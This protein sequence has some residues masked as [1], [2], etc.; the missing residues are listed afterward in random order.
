MDRF[1][2]SESTQFSQEWVV[3]VQKGGR[4][5]FNTSKSLG[6]KDPS[7]IE[8][9]LASKPHCWFRLYSC[10]HTTCT[11]HTNTWTQVFFFLFTW[12]IV[13]DITI[14]LATESESR[15]MVWKVKCKMFL[16]A[17]W[18]SQK[19][20]EFCLPITCHLGKCQ[21]I[22]ELYVYH[23]LSILFCRV[24]FCSF[25]FVLLTNYFIEHENYIMLYMKAKFIKLI[26][27]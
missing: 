23:V 5:I 24:F 12:F 6:L 21:W 17:M 27:I 13:Y 15:W 25:V 14:M 26:V 1:L 11:T 22:I 20:C 18:S 7:S 4:K 9:N 16:H 3:S 2:M 10:H 19:L 8:I